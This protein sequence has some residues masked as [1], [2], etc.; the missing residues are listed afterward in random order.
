MVDTAKMGNTDTILAPATAKKKVSPQHRRWCWT[1]NNPDVDKV[2]TLLSILDSQAKCYVF[3]L[4]RGDNG[5]PHFQGYVEFKNGRT[6]EGVKKLVSPRAHLEI[7]KGDAAANYVY[8][9]KGP[10]AGPWIKGLSPPVTSDII[11]FRP[12]QQQVWDKYRGVP[13]KRKIH[14]LWESTGN[15][16]KTSLA[17]HMCLQGDTIYVCGKAADVKCAIAKWVGDHK[18]LRAIVWDLPRTAQGY[19]SYAGLEEVKNG[20]FFN[21]KYESGMVLYNTC[22]VFVFANFEP[23]TNALSA[24][25]WDI[26]NINT[27]P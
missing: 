15:T 17:K 22:H 10:I 11:E 27:S 9:T 1:E 23:D 16:G 2:D 26:H 25:R 12:W 8:C 24:D 13:E 20:I 21:G 3:S 7:A 5:T 4:E 18:P 6:L 14:W 19:V